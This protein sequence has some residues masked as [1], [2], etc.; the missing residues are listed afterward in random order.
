MGDDQEDITLNPI[1]PL[2]IGQ[3]D[4]Q[5]WT[6]FARTMDGEIIMTRGGGIS[7]E[8][9]L[10]LSQYLEEAAQ[11]YRAPHDRRVLGLLDRNELEADINEETSNAF[12]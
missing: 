7:F 8:G 11:E 10:V 4:I 12:Y 3:E 5:H 1:K 9:A 6:F 2:D